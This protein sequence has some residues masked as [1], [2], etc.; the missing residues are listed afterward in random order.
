MKHFSCCHWNVNRLAA[1]D[2]KK[3]LLLEAYNAIH[4]YNLI[5]A[6]ERDL[7][8]LISNDEKD[9]S[10]K[11]YSL[12]RADHSSNTK[13]GGVCIYYKES[14]GVRIIDIP[15]LTE[16]ILCQI[17]IN[18]KTGYVL[19]VYRFS[20]QSSDDFENFLSTSDQVITDMSLSNPAFRLI[21][22]DF[23]CMSNSWRKGNISTKEGIDLESVS[24]SYGL[25]QRI[26]DPTHIPPQSSSCIDLIFIAQANLV[27]DSGVH[28]ALH[29]N[30]HHQITHCKLNL[31]VVFP[32][33]YECLVWN[34]KKAD[35]TAIR[36]ALDLVNWD[37]IFLN[38]TVHDQV[39][40]LDQFLINI[41]T[42]Y[43]TNKCKSFDGQ[44]PLWMNDCTE[45]KI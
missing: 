10:I 11:G 19:A 35:V 32:S 36:K 42:N 21:L 30:C 34:Y 2:Y 37:F 44:D 13:R 3:V 4:H 20:S 27:I 31:K 25:H 9:I 6:L 23:N 33:L 17:T 45:S 5:Y 40:A 15:N 22:G 39:L 14:L 18:N 12:V 38:K 41:F 26:T 7:D 8:S 43:I 24:S 28:S 16:S 29:A 1:H